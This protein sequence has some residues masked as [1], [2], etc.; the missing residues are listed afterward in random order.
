MPTHPFPGGRL[1]LLQS[2]MTCGDSAIPD[3]LA[4]HRAVKEKALCERLASIPTWVS[5]NTN[6]STNKFVG[7]QRST[8][9]KRERQIS[10]CRGPSVG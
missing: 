9:N 1:L 2:G 5:I 4:K 7:C 6:T 3:E 10:K 8:A